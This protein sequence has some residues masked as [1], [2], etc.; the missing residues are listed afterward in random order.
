MIEC[1]EITKRH[2]DNAI[3]SIKE[4]EFWGLV[5]DCEVT[6][7]SGHRIIATGLGKNVPIC[8]KFEGAMLSLGLDCHFMHSNNAIHGD[9]GMVR[10]GDLVIIL[11]KSAS[12]IESIIL[13]EH[14]KEKNCIIWLL[15]FSK[16][17]KLYQEIPRHLVVELEHEDDPWGIIPNNSSTLNLIILQEIAMQLAIRLKVPLSQFKTNHPGGAIGELLSHE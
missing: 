10:D 9:L 6:L 13:Y 8:E 4:D 15:T 2:L 17:G 1:L 14:L 3:N 16:E 12:T 5:N 11:T 7:K